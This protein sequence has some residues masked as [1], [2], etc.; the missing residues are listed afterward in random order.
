MVDREAFEAFVKSSFVQTK[1]TRSKLL[2]RI[3]GAEISDVRRWGHA[4]KNVSNFS[5]PKSGNGF[6]LGLCAVR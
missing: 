3:R 6:A 4:A 1:K 2:T 5:N